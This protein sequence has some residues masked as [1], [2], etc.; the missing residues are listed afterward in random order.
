MKNPQP[1]LN[2]PW[3]GANNT[4]GA[5]HDEFISAGQKLDAALSS[6]TRMGAPKNF[7]RGNADQP[8]FWPCPEDRKTAPWNMAPEILTAQ[9]P[10]EISIPHIIGGEDQGTLKL[11]L[12]DGRYHGLPQNGAN[13]PGILGVGWLKD[14]NSGTYKPSPVTVAVDLMTITQNENGELFVLLG[15]RP[16]FCTIGGIKDKGENEIQALARETLEEAFMASYLRERTDLSAEEKYALFESQNP[17]AIIKTQNWISEKTTI[18]YTGL[19]LADPRNTSDRSMATTVFS[20]FDKFKDVESLLAQYG[21]N[22]HEMSDEIS[23]FE[24]QKIT[25]ELLGSMFG[26]HAAYL[27]YALGTHIKSGEIELKPAAQTQLSTILNAAQT[28]ANAPATPA[29]NPAP[30]A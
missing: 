1:T 26:S 19:A 30:S 5:L 12:I 11:E 15:S 10:S 3:D 24:P 22:P 23:K 21:I 18:I 9:G 7:A 6:P 20:N 13:G 2:A 4:S 17:E 29:H 27:L 16:E 8:Q 25:P 14:A 28:L